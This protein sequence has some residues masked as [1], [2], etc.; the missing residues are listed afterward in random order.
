MV[1]RYS[2]SARHKMS[3]K[4][5]V[6]CKIVEITSIL[7]STLCK[8]KT[9]LNSVILFLEFFLRKVEGPVKDKK[10]LKMYS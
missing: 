6:K 9:V 3:V 10:A 2:V 1:N 7:S 4:S 5:A 8:P